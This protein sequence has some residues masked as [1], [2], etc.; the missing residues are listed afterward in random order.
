MIYR[1]YKTHDAL[2]TAYR[3]VILLCS[4]TEQ[5]THSRMSLSKPANFDQAQSVVPCDVCEEE[6]GEHYCTVCRQTL[7]D[8][9]KKYHKKVAATKDHA[10]VPRVQMASAVASTSCSRHPD[11]TV[12]LECEPCKILVCMKCVTGEH[13]GH[14]MKE[15][16]S[17]YEDEKAKL[18]KDIRELE[19]KTIP[20]LTN[21][22]K[23]INP[24]REEYK[25]AVSGIR[26]EMNDEIKELKSRLDEIH[27]DRL[28]RLA[29]AETSGLGQFD[30]IQQGL[31]DQK[32]LYI[33][34]VSECKAKIASNNQAQFLSYARVRGQKAHKHRDPIL[35]FPS[36]PQ[37]QRMKSEMMDISEL[38]AKLK[39]STAASHQGTNKQLVEPTVISTFKSKLKGLP[40][41]CLTEDGNAWVGGSG[42]KE[43][44]LVECNGKVLRTRPAKNRPFHLAMS[45]S[46]DIILSPRGDDSK[47]VMKLRADGTERPLLDVSPSFSLGVSVTQNGDIL[48]CVSGGRVMRC[49]GNGGNVQQIYDGKK[50]DTA[51]HAIELP[52]SKICIADAANKALVIIDKN[53]KIIQ[54]I[55]KPLSV[56]DFYPQGLACDSIGN[57]LSVDSNNDRVYIISQ[58]GEVREL[59]GKSH[60]IKEPMWLAVDSY[61]NMWV[62]QYDGNIKVVKYMA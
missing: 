20:S 37:I 56:Q 48:V 22:I 11:Q 47:T 59:S 18:E 21:A 24:K 57:I 51:I 60:W 9:C 50:T 23:D 39:I 8:W 10:V 52:D 4:D 28:K 35:K 38:L 19:Q 32:R 41:I 53:G 55:N 61:D 3:I 15:L 33:D 30:L 17:I 6:S 36:P 44:R 62:A 12:S 43:L 46:G 25:K 27:A 2:I 49:N 26:K 45:S 13:S 58:N 54:Q 7:C 42:S 16:S 31:E 14:R 34:D 29:V 5:Q 1:L 40:S